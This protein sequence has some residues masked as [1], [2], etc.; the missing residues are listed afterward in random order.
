[1]GNIDIEHSKMPVIY[2]GVLFRS[3]RVRI[4]VCIKDIPIDAIVV[5]SWLGLKPLLSQ[6]RAILS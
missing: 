2:I 6:A 5:M 3:D 1:M 4:G